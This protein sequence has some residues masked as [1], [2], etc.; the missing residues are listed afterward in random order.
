M[1]GLNARIIKAAGPS[2]YPVLR[3]IF[4]LSLITQTFPDDW[5]IGCITPIFKEG[6]ATNPSNYHP[7]LVLPALGKLLECV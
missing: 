7:I 1:D 5:K 3:H 4:N 2:I 6:D